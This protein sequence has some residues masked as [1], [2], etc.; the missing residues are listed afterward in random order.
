MKNYIIFVSLAIVCAAHAK[1]VMQDIN[2]LA[3]YE[4]ALDMNFL[5]EWQQKIAGNFAS[6][7]GSLSV[8]MKN[9]T[10]GDLFNLIIYYLKWMEGNFIDNVQDILKL[11]FAQI[12]E[13]SM[14]TEELKEKVQTRLS[15]ELTE[16]LRDFATLKQSLIS[17]VE[18]LSIDT[19]ENLVKYVER[20]F[21][22]EMQNILNNIAELSE[23]VVIV[24]D[25]FLGEK[26]Q[27]LTYLIQMFGLDPIANILLNLSESIKL[28]LVSIAAL[29]MFASPTQLNQI[30]K[31][32]DK[33]IIDVLANPSNAVPLIMDAISQ[34]NI[35]MI[36]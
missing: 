3:R 1:P 14:G 22:T 4:S 2:F 11:M 7:I 17:W 23:F 32:F 9:L 31:I 8:L 30:Q 28:Q 26:S 27:L 34:I 35:I 19:A 29:I 36:G 20:V 24:I 18:T 13:G 25:F 21:D 5:N 10:L 16:L 12:V 15:D 6:L 33:L